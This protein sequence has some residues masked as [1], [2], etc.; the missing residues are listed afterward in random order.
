MVRSAGSGE[1]R[2]GR[3]VSNCVSPPWRGGP[4]LFPLWAHLPVGPGRVSGWEVAEPG[5]PCGL[6]ERVTGGEAGVGGPR[7]AAGRAA[8]RGRKRGQPPRRRHQVGRKV[9]LEV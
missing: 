7:G 1:S 9:M 5:C 4:E 8:P 2:R 6:R 3:G